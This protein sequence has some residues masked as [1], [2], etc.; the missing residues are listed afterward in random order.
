MVE[1]KLQKLANVNSYDINKWIDS[2]LSSWPALPEDEVDYYHVD[3]P[4]LSKLLM[5]SLLPKRFPAAKRVE[6]LFK[7]V[8]GNIL[9]TI[10]AAE[11]YNQIRSA[12]HNY[13]E[14]SKI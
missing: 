10:Q 11:R 2:P 9:F 14:G 8:K 13:Y 3:L 7:F 12:W 6:R 5:N 4:I 1:E